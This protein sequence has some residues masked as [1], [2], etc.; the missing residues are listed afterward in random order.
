MPADQAHPTADVLVDQ[1]RKAASRHGG[2]ASD[3]LPYSD[4]R[5]VPV[6][7]PYANLE[8]LV[9]IRDRLDYICQGGLTPSVALDTTIRQAP[10]PQISIPELEDAIARAL[11]E[12]PWL[13][14][15][16]KQII[17]TRLEDVI[18]RWKDGAK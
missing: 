4:E 10:A 14:S 11:G 18:R 2:L 7:L 12:L 5:G 8:L 17:R 3:G 13:D 9:E 15:G 6:A 16:R 1:V